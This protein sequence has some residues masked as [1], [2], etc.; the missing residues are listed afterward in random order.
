MIKQ[1]R[2][3][4]LDEGM[5]FEDAYSFDSNFDENEAQSVALDAS[6]DYYAEREGWRK[7]DWPLYIEVFKEDKSS[8]GV[9]NVERDREL[10]H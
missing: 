6:V 1:Y 2:Y 3:A 4:L 10:H 9:F 5:T 7:A 8:L